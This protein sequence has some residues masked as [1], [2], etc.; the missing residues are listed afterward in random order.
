MGQYLSDEQFNEV[1]SKLFEA[2]G[3]KFHSIGRSCRGDKWFMKSTWTQAQSK[4][5]EKWLTK[6]VAKKL[7]ILVKSAKKKAQM[8]CLSYGWKYKD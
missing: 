5:F 4:E 3:K 6:Y 7:G 1:M 2:V 8:F